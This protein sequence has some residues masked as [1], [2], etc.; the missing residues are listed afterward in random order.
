[1]QYCDRLV[2]RVEVG[3][4]LAKA[5]HSPIAHCLRTKDYPLPARRCVQ[6]DRRV[7]ETIDRWELLEKVRRIEK[8]IIGRAARTHSNSDFSVAMTEPFWLS[9]S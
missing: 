9:T 7:R 5:S 1:M 8:V 3:C 4:R 6:T 2:C